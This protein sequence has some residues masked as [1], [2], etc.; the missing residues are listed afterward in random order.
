MPDTKGG[1][2]YDLTLTEEQYGYVL[3]V[4]GAYHRKQ[5]KG[6]RRFNPVDPGS[7]LAHRL[8]IGKRMLGRLERMKAAS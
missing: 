6:S 3:M 4:I 7:S 8:R 1:R 2:T 5:V